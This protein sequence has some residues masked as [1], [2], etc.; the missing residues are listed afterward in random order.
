MSLLELARD[1]CRRT[2]ARAAR[3]AAT[4]NGR[5]GNVAPLL[6]EN[7]AVLLRRLR[8]MTRVAA[9][10][11]GD[12]PADAARICARSSEEAADA[13]TRGQSHSAAETEARV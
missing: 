11:I 2:C 12:T 6:S 8:V 5:D 7:N 13:G 4:G 1:C 9:L 3:E 10:T